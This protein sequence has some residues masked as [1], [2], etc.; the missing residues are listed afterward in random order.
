ML[1]SVIAPLWKRNRI[2]GSVPPSATHARTAP[3][4]QALL[5][6]FGN[7]INF[8]P[9]QEDHIHYKYSFISHHIE[10]SEFEILHFSVSYLSLKSVPVSVDEMDD[11]FVLRLHQTL[12][13]DS[14]RR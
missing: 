4:Q 7:Q 8:K 9:F 6:H 5:H 3:C 2:R 14:F 10:V 1:T 12:G 11:R 13:V